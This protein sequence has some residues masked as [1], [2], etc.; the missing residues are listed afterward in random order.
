[1]KFRESLTDLNAALTDH[2]FVSNLFHWSRFGG[3]DDAKTF[4]SAVAAKS[5]TFVPLLKAFRSMSTSQTVGDLVAKTR[6]Q[7]DI[8]SLAL[9]VDFD[10]LKKLAADVDLSTL[11]DDDRSVVQ[12]LLKA[13]SAK[14]RHFMDDDD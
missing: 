3:D 7:L 10:D 9:F 2:R 6:W 14:R 8:A 12:E 13:K 4:I 5:D 11:D 1:M